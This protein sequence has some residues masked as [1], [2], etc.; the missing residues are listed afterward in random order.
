[1]GKELIA[2]IKAKLAAMK[3]VEASGFTDQTR[4]AEYFKE[5]EFILEEI[6]KTL[7][8]VADGQEAETEALK[9]T[10]KSLR[11]ELKTK[12]A[13]PKELTRRELCYSIGKGIAA[14]W[15]GNQKALS[16]LSFSPNLRA[17]QN[18]TNPKDISW[19]VGKG[20]NMAV[21]KAALD[22]PMGVMTTSDQY[23]INPIYE[24]ELM[25]E[26]AKK[27]VMMP[28]VRHRPMAEALEPIKELHAIRLRTQDVTAAMTTTERVDYLN[29]KAE[30]FLAP[31][32]KTLY[33]DLVGQGKLQP[34]P[35]AVGK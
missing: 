25:T 3:K 20:W 10:V 22:D 4:A 1:M 16:E 28:L 15:A 12:A 23:L 34:R 6:V 17:D 30:A 9:A 21:E 24:T 19:T 8:A 13:Y 26:A 32:G 29:K 11:D 14:A 31:M 5:K 35:V 33:Y 27:S 2:A 18:W 7:E